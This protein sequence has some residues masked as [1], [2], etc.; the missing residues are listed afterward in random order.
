MRLNQKRGI[1]MLMLN[2]IVPVSPKEKTAS[3]GGGGMGACVF[4]FLGLLSKCI[5]VFF[6]RQ[7]GLLEG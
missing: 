7:S 6:F 3:R 5:T 4:V 2:F 1:L